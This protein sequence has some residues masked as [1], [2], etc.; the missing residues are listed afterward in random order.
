MTTEIYKKASQKKLRF[1]T[2]VGMLTC[3]Q[4]FDFNLEQLDELAVKYNEEHEKSSTKSYLSTKSEEDKTAKLKFDIVLDILNT[5]LSNQERA[6][7]GEATKLQNQKILAILA[8]KKDSELMDLSVEE[9]EAKL[10][11]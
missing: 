8:Q 10:T 1:E 4:L 3:E 2:S 11:T 6:A 9:L 5:K 7:K